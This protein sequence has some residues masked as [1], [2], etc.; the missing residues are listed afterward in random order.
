MQCF[1]M[2]MITDEWDGKESTRDR[3][4]VSV[5]KVGRY[6]IDAAT[7]RSFV[8]ATG[9][10]TLKSRSGGRGTGG[11]RFRRR[12]VA[13]HTPADQLNR[14]APLIADVANAVADEMS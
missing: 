4:A 7:G 13:Y 10:E 14:I 8:A 6:L 2:M 5:Y 1:S 3:R 9:R 11:I 12:L